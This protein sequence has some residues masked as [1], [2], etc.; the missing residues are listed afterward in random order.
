MKL[1][2]PIL[3]FHDELKQIRRSIHAH[4]ELSYEEFK[5]SDLVAAK[6]TEWGIPVIRG[7]GGTGVVGVISHVAE[8]KEWVH[9]R[10]VVERPERR[11]AHAI[12]EVADLVLAHRDLENG[13]A[14][15]GRRVRSAALL[16]Y[17]AAAPTDPHHI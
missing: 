17:G 4:P 12:V 7:L 11:I 16:R 6:L 2:D 13:H 15:R 10:I 5:T 8:M 1:I 3:A 9:D 14:G